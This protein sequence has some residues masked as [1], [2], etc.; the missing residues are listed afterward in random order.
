SL[1]SAS[2]VA[3]SSFGCTGAATDAGSMVVPLSASSFDN[4]PS[5]D[6]SDIIY[7]GYY[8]VGVAVSSDRG[9]V[10]PVL[11]DTDRMSMADVEAG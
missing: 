8:D 2:D 9:L 7:H 6:G 4:S 10:V 5:F 1:Y 11:R 3:D